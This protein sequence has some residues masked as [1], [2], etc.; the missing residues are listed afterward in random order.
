MSDSASILHDWQ[1]LRLRMIRRHDAAFTRDEWAYLVQFLDPERLALPWRDSFGVSAG[2]AGQGMR[3]APRQR[4]ALWLPNNVSLL[5]CLALVLISL[6]GAQVRVKAGSRGRDLCSH[7]AAFAADSLPEGPLRDWW[8]QRVCIE[9]FDRLDARNAAMSAWADARILFGGDEAAVSVA[10]LPHAAGTPFLSFGHKVSEAWC[11]VAAAHDPAAAQALAKAFSIY[12]QAGCTSPKRVVIVGGSRD[13]ADALASGM[14]VHWR[15]TEPPAQAHASEVVMGEQWARAQGLEARRLAHNGALLVLSP[16]QPAR[17]FAHL[18]LQLQWGSLPDVVA[19]GAAN[20]QTV[21]HTESPQVPVGW[22]DAFSE[23][24]GSRF[25]P[26]SRMHDFSH[27][28]DG[29]AWW[30]SLFRFVEVAA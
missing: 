17:V 18:G 15:V 27:V 26:V 20:L 2:M 21:G 5:G 9:V 6:T 25:V 14:A 30:K 3:V 29:L 28:W 22:V 13:D 1:Q 16:V 24:A 12:G 4:V 7:F 10:G 8:T 23:T 19:S 11:S